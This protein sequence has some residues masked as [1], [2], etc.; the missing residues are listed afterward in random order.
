MFTVPP[1]IALMNYMR[2]G[3]TLAEFCSGS[4]Q[5]I[6]NSAGRGSEAAM[7][8]ARDVIFHSPGGPVKGNTPILGFRG[9]FLR[10]R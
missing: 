6:I 7:G 9:V 1:A 3:Y 2:S 5:Y 4:S 10:K 8:G